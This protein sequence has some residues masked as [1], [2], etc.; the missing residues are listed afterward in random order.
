MDKKTL[1][2]YNQAIKISLK[3]LEKYKQ[4]IGNIDVYDSP[5][6]EK[7]RQQCIEEIPLDKDLLDLNFLTGKC[8]CP[9]WFT[10]NTKGHNKNIWTAKC[11]FWDKDNPNSLIDEDFWDDVLK[12]L[13]AKKLSGKKISSPKKFT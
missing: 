6:V 12:Q 1:S 4:E 9:D 7:I 8:E 13:K 5:I 11:W 2:V 10:C 3:I